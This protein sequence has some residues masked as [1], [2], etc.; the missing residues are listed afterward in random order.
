M[1][2]LVN[3]VWQSGP[4]HDTD[5][6]GGRFVRRDSI[7]RNWVRR[8]GTTPFAPEAG[9]YHLYVVTGCP[10]AHRTLIFRCLKKLEGTISVT[11]LVPEMTANGWVFPK[12]PAK[13]YEPDPLYGLDYLYQ[14][15]LKADPKCNGKATVP[16]LW[17]KKRETIVNNESSE[18]I[19][20][21]NS[22]FDDFGDASVDFY[23][24]PLRAEIDEINA[25]VYDRVNNGVYKCGFATTQ[26]A[27]EEAY[28]QL[29]ETLDMLEERLSRRRYLVGDRITEADWR[30]YPTLLRFDF[31]YYGY[32]KCNKRR[33]L[34]YPNLLN[35]LRELYQTPGIA[36]LAPI[37]DF[38]RMYYSLDGAWF[39]KPVI[40]PKGPENRLGE[41]HDRGR[42]PLAAE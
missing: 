14:L 7:F 35:Y 3:G 11:R 36:E 33:I 19:R 8:D 10:W 32:F 4:H 26:E 22:E 23:P 40:V 2:L 28:D 34:D 9:R 24:K 37:E 31:V 21:L 29:F 15:Y 25:V 18:I 27:Y 13:T 17:D 1:G 5:R 42:V 12:T 39:G 38:K 6:T 30:L 16:V 41:P 20:M